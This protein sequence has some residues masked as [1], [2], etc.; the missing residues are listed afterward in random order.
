MSALA[1][2]LNDARLLD[3]DLSL[4]LHYSGEGCFFALIGSAVEG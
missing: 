2:G 1:P 3:S 4:V